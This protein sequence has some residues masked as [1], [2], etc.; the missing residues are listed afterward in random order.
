[1]LSMDRFGSSSQSASH[2]PVASSSLAANGPGEFS[3]EERSV[4]SSVENPISALNLA[5]QKYCVEPPN[6]A[7]KYSEDVQ[8]SRW[9]QNLLQQIVN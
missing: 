3:R 8:Q 7:V 4:M 5:V 6:I 2:E 9:S 1:M